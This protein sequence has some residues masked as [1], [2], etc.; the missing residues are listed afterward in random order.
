MASIEWRWVPG[1]EGRYEVSNDGRV[2]SHTARN[3]RDL[4]PN[5][6]KN[7]YRAVQLWRDNKPT[8]AYVHRLVAAAFVAGGGDGMDVRHLDGSRDNNHASN[9]A[10]GTRQDNVNDAVAHGT[11]LHK[12]KLNELEVRAIRAISAA[13]EH[14]RSIL[15]RDIA[16]AFGI[17]PETVTD[18]TSG[19]TWSHVD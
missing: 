14:Y 18:I 13:K 1:W 8:G 16:R 7:G 17:K 3:P 15:R 9:L 10:W 19:R 2:R 12:A 4:S 5:Y 11:A 6:M